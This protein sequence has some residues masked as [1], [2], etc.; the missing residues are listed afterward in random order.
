M[1]ARPL[2]PSSRRKSSCRCFLNLMSWTMGPQRRNFAWIDRT[3]CPAGGGEALRVLTIKYGRAHRAGLVL[4]SSSLGGVLKA[5]RASAA[6]GGRRPLFV[7]ADD[8]AASGGR[9]SGARPLGLG[10]FVILPGGRTGAGRVALPVVAWVCAA[11]QPRPNQQR[12]TD[13]VYVYY[14]ERKKKEASKKRARHHL[15]HLDSWFSFQGH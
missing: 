2:G 12:R 11:A 8:R 7:G 15:L 13:S 4:S 9:R 3:V 14:N 6:S 5:E 10:H 1:G